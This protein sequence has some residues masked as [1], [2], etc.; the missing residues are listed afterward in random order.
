MV[1]I[2]HLGVVVWFYYISVITPQTHTWKI[3]W[4][5]VRRL[6]S[7]KLTQ[8]DVNV[9]ERKNRIWLHNLQTIYLITY[10]TLQIGFINQKSKRKVKFVANKFWKSFWNEKWRY[11]YFILAELCKKSFYLIIACWNKFVQI[12]KISREL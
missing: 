4:N 12:G 11:Q 10:A 9:D 6:Y 7:S 5:Y 2:C 3:H 1:K 8:S